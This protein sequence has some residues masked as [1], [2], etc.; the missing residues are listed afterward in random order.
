MQWLIHQMPAEAERNLMKL[1]AR[2]CRRKNNLIH[3]CSLEVSALESSFAGHGQRSWW[4]PSGTQA[5]YVSG[6]QKWCR[7]SWAA[8]GRRLQKVKGGDP[9]LPHSTSKAP[10][11]VLGPVLGFLLKGRGIR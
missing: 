7:E 4:T 11:G 6:G 5:S 3:L 9:S 8:L 10:A 1:N 2:K